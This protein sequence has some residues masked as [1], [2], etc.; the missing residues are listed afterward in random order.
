MSRALVAALATATLATSAGAAT[1]R[2]TLS[3]ADRDP[4][5]IFLRGFEPR[6]VVKVTLSE[7]APGARR[8]L[9]TMQGRAF[10][11]FPNR[12]AGPCGDV[13]AYASGNKGSS[14]RLFSNQPGC[15]PIAP[16]S[17]TAAARP[18]LRVID[19]APLTVRGSHFAPLERVR[20]TVDAKTDATRT[21]STTGLGAF[22]VRFRNLRLGWCPSYAVTAVGTKGSRATFRVVPRECP[23]PP[24]PP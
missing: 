7:P 2:P 16:F 12:S 5:T 15:P 11:D 19:T 4:V 22:F 23:P 1:P 14:A 20:V 18:T 17:A 13:T 21:V 10:V 6:E 24:P 8:V 9:T 3:I